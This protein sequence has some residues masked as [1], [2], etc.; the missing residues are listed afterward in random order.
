MAVESSEGVSSV[1][2]VG[3]SNVGVVSDYEAVVSGVVSANDDLGSIELFRHR[4]QLAGGKEVGVL[5]LLDKLLDACSEFL[6]NLDGLSIC[7]LGVEGGLHDGCDEL[8]SGSTLE[9]SRAGL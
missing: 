8:G 3:A 1:A 7:F 6:T 4:R 9:K 2:G 5:L